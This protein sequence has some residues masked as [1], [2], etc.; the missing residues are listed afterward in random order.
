MKSKKGNSS[1]SKYDVVS[2]SNGV[3]SLARVRL[4]IPFL[5]HKRSK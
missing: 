5:Q 4:F 2:L 1:N 3:N